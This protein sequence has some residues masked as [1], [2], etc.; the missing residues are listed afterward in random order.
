MKVTCI[1]VSDWK[2]VLWAYR[3][4]TPDQRAVVIKDRARAYLSQHS[5][6]RE[7]HFRFECVWPDRVHTHIRTHHIGGEHYVGTQRP[8]RGGIAEPMRYHALSVNAQWLINT[9]HWRLCNRPW[10]DTQEAMVLIRDAVAEVDS[11]LARVMVPNCVFQ[12]GC[13]EPRPC[14]YYRDMLELYRGYPM[15]RS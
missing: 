5:P 8:D 1:D 3:S 10:N 2:W 15:R 12:G 4:T 7:R 14:G 9:S 6:I 13:P 11:A